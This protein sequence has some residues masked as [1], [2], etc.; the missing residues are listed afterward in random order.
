MLIGKPS[1]KSFVIWRI[2]KICG[3]HMEDSSWNLSDM[4]MQM[5]IWLKIA[6]QFWGMLL[7]Y[8]EVLF[9]GALNGRR[10][11]HFLLQKVNILQPLIPQRKPSGF[12]LS[13]H[14]SLPPHLPPLLYFQTTSLQSHW[15]RTIS[16]IQEQNISTYDFISSGGSS[17]MAHF[18]SFIVH[19]ECHR[20]ANP[21][22][23]TLRVGI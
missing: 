13:S 16:I 17:K 22:G 10:S 6:M 3:C 9:L 4:L 5:K 19:R 11:F 7:F 8:M 2:Q 12:V 23:L 14:S 18:D 15:Q 21:C 1:R 20:F